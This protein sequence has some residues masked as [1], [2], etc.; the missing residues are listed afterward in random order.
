MTSFFKQFLSLSLFSF[1]ATSALAQTLHYD[2]LLKGGHV[3]DPANHIDAVMDVA[4]SSGCLLY[5]S[6]S[7]RD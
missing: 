2:L 3:V 7:P 1:L 6:P 4:V 5:T